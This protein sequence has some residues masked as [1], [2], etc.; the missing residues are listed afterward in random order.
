MRK[1]IAFRLNRPLGVNKKCAQ[2][3]N[4]CKQHQTLLIILCP[5]FIS[6]KRNTPHP[7]IGEGVKKRSLEAVKSSGHVPTQAEQEAPLQAN[8][9][10]LPIISKNVE[11]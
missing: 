4:P 6:R 2:C 5:A 1:Q 3:A 11:V 8:T 10:I 7:S 9:A